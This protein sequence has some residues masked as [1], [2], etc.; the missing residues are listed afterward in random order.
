MKLFKQKHIQHK[1]KIVYFDVNR[2]K[3]V[4]F[5]KKIMFSE[6]QTYGIVGYVPAFFGR[7]F[8]LAK[9]KS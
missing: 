9:L 3:M 1:A 6:S 7:P 2:K 5:G 4:N 8:L